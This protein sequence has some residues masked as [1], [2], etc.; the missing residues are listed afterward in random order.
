MSGLHVPLDVEYAA[1]DAI[2]DAGPM[3]ELL[4]I[5]GLAFCKRTMSDGRITDRQLSSVALGINAAK[6][7]AARLVEVGL[8]TRGRDHWAIVNW[9]KYNAPAAEIEA[10]RDMAKANGVRGNH[11]RWHLDEN[12]V[13]AKPSPKCAI[14]RSMY[15]PPDRPPD[16]GAS[17][18]PIGG[19]IAKE[20]PEPE[21]EPQ[22]E[23]QPLKEPYSSSARSVRDA[24]GEL[25]RI[26]NGTFGRIDDI[27]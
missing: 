26:L 3:A 2:I 13:L 5:R 19:D 12:G 27:A 23:P 7:H 14:C 25:G 1:D 22:P 24:R 6:K 18:D 4:Y 16:G 21:E 8:W 20:E 15:R 11:E 9:L 17:P 10:A